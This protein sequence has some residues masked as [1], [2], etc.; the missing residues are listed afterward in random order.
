MMTRYSSFEEK[1]LAESKGFGKRKDNLAKKELESRDRYLMGVVRK[2]GRPISEN[3]MHE[4][5]NIL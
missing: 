4:L 2:L 3:E 1:L 5:A